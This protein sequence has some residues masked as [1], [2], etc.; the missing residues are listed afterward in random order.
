M[1]AT[2]KGYLVGWFV[3][4]LVRDK[5][6]WLVYVREKY[7][8]CWKFTIVYDKPQPNEQAIY[9]FCIYMRFAIKNS[10]CPGNSCEP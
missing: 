10:I 3:S 2:K 1:A 7:C 5:Y 6:C 8:F 4:L 9:V